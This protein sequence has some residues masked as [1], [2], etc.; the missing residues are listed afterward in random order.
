MGCGQ[1]KPAEGETRKKSVTFKDPPVDFIE[2]SPNAAFVLTP[3]LKGTP[4]NGIYPPKPPKTRR[5][6]IIPDDTIFHTLDDHALKVHV[7]YSA[8]VTYF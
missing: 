6:E 8:S 3:Q 1:T 7:V 4:D 2:P 5:R